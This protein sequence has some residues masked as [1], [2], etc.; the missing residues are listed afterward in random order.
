MRIHFA[1]FSRNHTSGFK[2][3]FMIVTPKNTVLQNGLLP[4][5]SCMR[6]LCSWES[7]WSYTQTCEK[8][9]MPVIDHNSQI[10]DQMEIFPQ[11]VPL[12]KCFFFQSF[13]ALHR[14]LMQHNIRYMQIR[15][16]CASSCCTTEWQKLLILLKHQ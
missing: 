5:C 8:F 15:R 14:L 13:I 3:I 1:P 12:W 9:R 6:P 4:F 11:K 2:W 16:L 7:V 10:L